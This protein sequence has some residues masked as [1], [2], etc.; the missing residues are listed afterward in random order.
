M[1]RTMNRGGPGFFR[2]LADFIL[3]CVMICTHKHCAMAYNA[4]TSWRNTNAFAA[5]RQDGHVVAWGSSHYGGSIPSSM[6]SELIN[7]QTIY[8]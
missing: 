2:F 1:S 4:A 3:L 6:S 7:V 5:L 8:S